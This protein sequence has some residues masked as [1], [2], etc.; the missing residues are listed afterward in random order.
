MAATPEGAGTREH[1]GDPGGGRA[2][3][4]AA[5]AGHAGSCSP[6]SVRGSQKR[7]MDRVGR[8]RSVSLCATSLLSRAIPQRVAQDWE[9]MALG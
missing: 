2:P 1:G 9:Q 4:M 8:T 7:G 5:A 3:N 6:S